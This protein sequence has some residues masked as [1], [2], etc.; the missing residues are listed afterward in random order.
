MILLIHLLLGARVD[1]LVVLLA[2]LLDGL[3]LEATRLHIIGQDTGCARVISSDLI[4]LL[5]A[6]VVSASG[7]VPHRVF[8]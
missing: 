8:D 5:L 1:H 2:S 3:S 4:G 7:S 6:R